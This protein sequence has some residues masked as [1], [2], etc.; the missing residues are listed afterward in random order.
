MRGDDDDGVS[1]FRVRG[2]RARLTMRKQWHQIFFPRIGSESYGIFA[3]SF[4]WVCVTHAKKNK[5]SAG[6]FY[7]PLLLCT[8]RC[9][10]KSNF[11][12]K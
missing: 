5:S 7:V 4:C 12:S 10:I 9:D 6:T 11:V 2:E 1:D 8:E 3:V